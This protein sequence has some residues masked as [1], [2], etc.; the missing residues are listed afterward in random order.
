MFRVRQAGTC[1]VPHHIKYVS[2]SRLAGYKAYTKFPLQALQ[3]VIK[4]FSC[5][6]I[7]VIRT[8]GNKNVQHK[9][10]DL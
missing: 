2:T 3:R 6:N 10:N 1:S 4:M 9:S 7:T 8:C 5:K